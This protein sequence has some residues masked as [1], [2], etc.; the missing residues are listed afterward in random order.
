MLTTL[1][2]AGLLGGGILGG[3]LW[4]SH[5]N[6][7][8]QK[9]LNNTLIE[10]ANTSH[11]REVADLKAAGLNPILSANGSGASVPSL[12]AV[13]Y[14]DLGKQVGSAVETGLDTV[15]AA[16]DLRGAMINNDLNAATLKERKEQV[17]AALS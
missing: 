13:H 5:Q 17:K 6:R 1:L 15:S 2:V 10:L 16:A 9:S 12:D 4:S 8:A 14:D 7:K 11:Q 3:S